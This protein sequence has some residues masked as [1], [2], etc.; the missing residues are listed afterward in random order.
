MPNFRLEFH[1]TVAQHTETSMITNIEQLSLNGV[2]IS[3]RTRFNVPVASCHLHCE[4]QAATTW[5]GMGTKLARH[6]WKFYCGLHYAILF[7]M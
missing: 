1:W 4:L 3:H 7:N 5:V 2:T 6:G